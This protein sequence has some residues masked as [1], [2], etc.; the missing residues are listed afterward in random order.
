MSALPIRVRLTLWYGTLLA[1]ALLLFAL[2]SFV[3]MRRVLEEQVDIELR[4]GLLITRRLV[5]AASSLDPSD[6]RKILIRHDNDLFRISGASGELLYESGAM[7]ALRGDEPLRGISASL[8]RYHIRY[9]LPFHQQQ[10]AIDRFRNVTLVSIPL[11]LFGATAGGFWLS[12]RALQPVRAII[13]DAHAVTDRNLHRRLELPPARDELH[14]L[15]Q[16]LN[17]MLD[18]LEQGF[19]RMV[20]FTADASHE[21]RTPVSIMRTI[22]EVALRRPRSSEEYCEAL[23]AIEFELQRTTR[24]IDDLLLLARAGAEPLE[25]EPVDVTVPLREAIDRIDALARARSID[26][27]VNV[28]SPLVVDGNRDQLHRMFLAILDNAIKFTPPNGRISIA[29]SDRM[30]AIRDTGAG[31]DPAEVERIFDRFYRTDKSRGRDSGGFGL[32]LAIARRIAELHGATIEVSS[33][34]SHGSEFCVCFS[35]S[36]APY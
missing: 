27:D 30:V 11:L 35:P 19:T 13:R 17:E 36:A 5:E 9:L 32:G 29:M 23:G 1:A 31:I 34:V 14:A 24:L 26:V 6:L 33:R 22:A 28:L 12:G 16:T 3:L 10:A 15:S 18:R 25:R 21:L 2:L 8:R 20:E 4:N 7:R